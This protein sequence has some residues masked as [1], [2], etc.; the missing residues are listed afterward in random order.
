MVCGGLYA[1]TT[2]NTGHAD[3]DAFE[4][5]FARYLQSL[6]R[7]FYIFF[8]Y[9]EYGTLY[10]IPRPRVIVRRLRRAIVRDI[11]TDIQCVPY[12]LVL[13]RLFI[14]ISRPF[15]RLL[16]PSF[17]FFIYIYISLWLI[18]VS[19][20]LLWNLGCISPR[21]A[22]FSLAPSRLPLYCIYICF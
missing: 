22:R 15:F 5:H 12:S 10:L 4:V 7:T 8:I 20:L 2:L 14:F 18:R 3:C 16:L 6:T 19:R 21:L 17:H 13:F 1:V 11:H 9:I